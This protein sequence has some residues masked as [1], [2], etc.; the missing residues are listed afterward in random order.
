MRPSERQAAIW[1]IIFQRR[2]ETVPNL[3][4]E[5]G[6]CERTIYTDI[7][8]MGS[9]YPIESIVGKHGGVYLTHE[10]RNIQKYLTPVQEKILR[11]LLL[12]QPM[13]VQRILQ[14]ILNAFARKY[15]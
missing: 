1:D 7:S 6:V 3:A 10:P 5:L 2:F 8:E 9:R 15:P 11:K 12:S 14:S 4:R 13:D